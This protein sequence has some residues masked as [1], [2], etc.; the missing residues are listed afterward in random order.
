MHFKAWR[1][2]AWRF[3]AWHCIGAMSAEFITK[4]SL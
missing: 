2:K 1:F 3:K 4:H